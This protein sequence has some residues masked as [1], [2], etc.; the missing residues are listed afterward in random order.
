MP[1]EKLTAGWEVA[2]VADLRDLL[3]KVRGANGGPSPFLWR[4]GQAQS[5]TCRPNA[6][7]HHHTQARQSK[8]D[9]VAIPLVHPR[10]QRDAVGVSD[11]RQGQSVSQSNQT[12]QSTSCITRLAH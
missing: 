1:L 10:F 4:L 5:S 8:F 7:H 3:E 12:G 9:F 6:H 11:A 2:A